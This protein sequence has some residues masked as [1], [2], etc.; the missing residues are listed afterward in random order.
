MIE[1]PTVFVVGAGGSEPYGLP[2]GYGLRRR[3]MRA[4]YGLDPI[5]D[6]NAD[7]ALTTTVG[8]VL[9]RPNSLRELGIALRG[10]NPLS[11]D[12]LLERRSDLSEVGKTAIAATLLKSE[13]FSN[14]VIEKGDWLGYL[15]LRI[16]SSFDDFPNNR[17]AF[18]TFNYDRII[19]HRLTLA[20][21]G[22]H[23]KKLKDAWAM[24]QSIPIVHVYGRL[25]RYSPEPRDSSSDA[26]AAVDFMHEENIADARTDSRINRAAEGIKLMH[27]REDSFPAILHAREVLKTA[28]RIFFLGFGYD[29]INICRISTSLVSRPAEVEFIGSAL[30][31]LDGEKTE[32]QSSI[33]ARFSVRLGGDPSNEI[34]IPDHRIRF[35][36]GDCLETLRTH[37]DLLR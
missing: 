22:H 34:S 30:N 10:T 11:I 21:A 24:V 29:E 33:S 12:T 9:G 6:K 8:R 27:E 37:S 3:I 5:E 4:I 17:I 2:T 35:V 36:D 19:E 32:A 31:L 7:A 25:G 26:D 15:Y 14:F 13:N 28:K 23:G 20:L 16:H 18:V 1:T